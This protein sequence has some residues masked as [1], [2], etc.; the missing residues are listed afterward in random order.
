[1]CLMNTNERFAGSQMMKENTQMNYYKRFD[2]IL[3]KAN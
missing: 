1:M 2:D 3:P